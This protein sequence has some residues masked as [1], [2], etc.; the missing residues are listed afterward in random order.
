MFAWVITVL[1][2]AHGH[3]LC[4]RKFDTGY[5]LKR[6]NC[7]F[8]LQYLPTE[9]HPRCVRKPLHELIAHGYAA[10]GRAVSN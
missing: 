8:V 7:E 5:F 10:V 1:V 4:H 6:T 3:A 2:C 9:R